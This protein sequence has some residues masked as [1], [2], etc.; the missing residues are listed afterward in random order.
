MAARTTTAPIVRSDTLPEL[1]RVLEKL[2]ALR[3]YLGDIL[4]VVLV[5]DA[6]CVQGELR[7][8]GLPAVVR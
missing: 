7:W 1:R 4:Q 5:L 8:R 2:P 6:S 3:D